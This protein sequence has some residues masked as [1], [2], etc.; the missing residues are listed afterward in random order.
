MTTSDVSPKRSPSWS[1]PC[2]LT[3]LQAREEGGISGSSWYNKSFKTRKLLA[4]RLGKVGVISDAHEGCI[5]TLK[6][7]RDGNLL[8]SG[9]DDHTVGIFKNVRQHTGKNPGECVSRISTGHTGNIFGIAFFGKD[10]RRMV[11]TASDGRVIVHCAQEGGGW[12]SKV[13]YGTPSTPGE[14]HRILPSTYKVV[15]EEDGWFVS[16]GKG[17]VWHFDAREKIGRKLFDVRKCPYVEKYVCPRRTFT[18]LDLYGLA[19]NPVENW[20]VATGGMDPHL[21]IWDRRKPNQPVRYFAPYEKFKR[22]HRGWDILH[23]SITSVNFSSDG[24]EIIAFYSGMGV[25]SF[26]LYA[27]KQDGKMVRAADDGAVSSVVERTLAE[28]PVLPW[29]GMQEAQD[30]GN[31]SSERAEAGK[32]CYS[33]NFKVD[34][35]SSCIFRFPMPLNASALG[36]IVL[37]GNDESSSE[38]DE[39]QNDGGADDESIGHDG[40]QTILANSE[41]DD[42]HPSY[43]RFYEGADNSETIKD[44]MYLGESCDYVMSGSDTGEIYIWDRNTAKLVQKLRNADS[45]SVNVVQG[46]PADDF[47]IASSGIDADIK[48]WAPCGS[49]E[50]Y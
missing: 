49:H 13:V 10:E 43:K 40:F 4:S 35:R 31:S 44:C 25:F 36:I 3:D 11:T 24:Q 50:E 47:F 29:M 16:N 8:Y 19:V 33:P 1:E 20:Y 17:A 9:S 28:Q 23:S 39:D 32:F 27:S 41:E 2:I 26:D 15:G 22:G 18:M 42:L 30:K 45:E 5:N 6:W 48:L 12:A 7:S 14:E 46:N 34:R 37:N 21:R 38:E